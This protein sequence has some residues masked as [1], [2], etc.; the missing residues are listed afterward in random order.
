MSAHYDFDFVAIGGG[1]GGFNGARTAA[2][3]GLK[4]AVIDGAEALGGL[5]ILRGCMPSKTLLYSAEVLHRARQGRLFGLRIPRAEG[6]M[7]ATQARKR[8]II[9]EFADDRVKA[10]TAGRF[11]LLRSPARFVDPHTVELADGRRVS[12]RAF[13]I[14]TGSVANVPDVPGLAQAETWT[15]DEA[16]DTAV[17]PRSLIVLGGGLVAVELA[18]FFARMGSRVTLLQRGAHLL[19]GHSAESAEVIA[20]ALRAD[21]IEVLCG[22]TLEHVGRRGRGFEVH[23]RLGRRRLSR[24]AD[25][26]LNAL[27]RRPAT[28]HLNL[29]AAGVR[30]SDNGQIV[31]R[32]FQ[33]TSAPHI[34][35][36]GDCAGPVEIVHIAVQQGEV[37]ARHAAGVRP[38]RPVNY[39]L[40]LSVVF[41]D[42]QL[43]TL[44]LSE[45]QL[46]SARTPFLS[47]SYPFDD[48][49]KSIL[50]E[51]KRGYVQVRAHA[52]TGRLLGAEIVGPDA[53]ELIHLFSGPM[54]MKA[55][56]F[57]LLKAP[58]Y[59]PTLSEI[60]TYPLDEIAEKIGG[61]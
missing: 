52:K 26:C 60:V 42:P 56:V 13:L 28:E 30:L 41:T 20:A 4:A 15:S 11:A 5:C 10:L 47:A 57:D 44:G 36:A 48:H 46:R 2:S 7:A 8:R 6:D 27:G 14:A 25:Q 34:Y 43:A 23:F 18:Q 9:G 33:Q 45:E 40:L 53:G 61:R 24:R 22:T 50:M 19:R 29:A 17:L 54:A 58:F 59:H 1:S 31:T 55:T 3:L 21:G 12:S 39:D 16:L 49:G 38:L 35:A 37:A 32:R 51:A